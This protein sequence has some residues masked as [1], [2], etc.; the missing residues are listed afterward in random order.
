MLIADIMA[1]FL[2]VRV[3]RTN[4]DLL[5]FLSWSNGEHE[6]DLVEHRMVVHLFGGTFSPSCVFLP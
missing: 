5:R 6:Q 1:M 2:Q 4:S 3:P